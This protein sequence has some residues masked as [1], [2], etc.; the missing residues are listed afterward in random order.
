MALPT[1][2]ER[3]PVSW[4]DISVWIAAIIAAVA[5]SVIYQRLR[6][7]AAMTREDH[8]ESQVDDLR[9]QVSSLQTTIGLMARRIQELED[10]NRNLRRL[11]AHTIVSPAQM[12]QGDAADVRRALE[13]LSA[14]E[15]RQ[16]AYEEFR[17]VYQGL[18]AEQSSQAL[19]L[20]LV[21]WAGNHGETDRLRQAILR[22][23]RA[24]FGE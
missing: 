14:E 16:M 4:A 5:V 21:E 1:Q 10:E 11:M 13:R 22:I 17:D 20:A 9:K 8:L 23:N 12:R 19:R 15:L 2:R 24:A 7:D 18:G 3:P 6:P